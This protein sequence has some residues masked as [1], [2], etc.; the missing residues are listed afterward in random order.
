MCPARNM[1]SIKY[2]NVHGMKDSRWV[3]KDKITQYKGLI[4][5][6]GKM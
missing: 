1:L 5:L 3:T 6:F 2:E 4:K